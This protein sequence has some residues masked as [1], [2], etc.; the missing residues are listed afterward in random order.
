MIL[1]LFH[2]QGF[3]QQN[4]GISKSPF[5]LHIA[6]PL[7]ILSLLKYSVLS[8]TMGPHQ[9][10]VEVIERPTN[11]YCAGPVFPNSV[12]DNKASWLLS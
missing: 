12:V 6:L 10:T 9:Q 7:N 3:G 2:I 8:K 1:H 11:E 4:P 5:T